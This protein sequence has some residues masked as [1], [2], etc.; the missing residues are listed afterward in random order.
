ME[1][2]GI[3]RSHYPG[4]EPAHLPIFQPPIRPR[5]PGQLNGRLGGQDIFRSGLIGGETMVAR[6]R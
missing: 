3:A 6:W 4:V 5:P 2:R 1:G